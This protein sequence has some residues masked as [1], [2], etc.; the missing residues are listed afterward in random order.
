MLAD[1][2]GT[3]TSPVVHS[4]TLPV[5]VCGCVRTFPFQKKSAYYKDFPILDFPTVVWRKTPRAVTKRIK[6]SSDTQ[7]RERLYVQFAKG[8]TKLWTAVAHWQI[9]VR[10][11]GTKC[12]RSS[13]TDKSGRGVSRRE[14]IIQS[15]WLKETQGYQI[16]HVRAALCKI[17]TLRALDG[18]IGAYNAFSM[19][20]LSFRSV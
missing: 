8:K 6:T 18:R 11:F 20:L 5:R 13:L 1:T 14:R 15:E 10:L 16:A 2:C 4:Q 3:F 17:G 7:R 19:E 9:A 12:G